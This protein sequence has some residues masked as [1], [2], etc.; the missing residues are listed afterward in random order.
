M[1]RT[2]VMNRTAAYFVLALLLGVLG[3]ATVAASRSTSPNSLNTASAPTK[4]ASSP[5]PNSPSPAA[6]RTP[7]DFGA[8]PH[9]DDSLGWLNTSGPS[10]P[11]NLTS[12][13]TLY[14]FWTFECYNCKNTLPTLRGLYQR[15]HQYGLEIV[16]IHTPEFAAER[17]H[18]NVTK[19]T[20][21][22]NVTWPVVF[23][24]HEINWHGWGNHY[25]PHI[26]VADRSARVRFDH[27][28]EGA[29][30]ELE[31]TIRA[32]LH[33]DPTSPRSTSIA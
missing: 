20:K 15:Y 11:P 13:V 16:G 6:L 4:A 24:D 3:V 28:G 14:E 10:V 29:Y 27:V 5:A 19:A 31:D 12:A 32:L 1:L 26:Y 9:L 23:D 8:V 21:D 30:D 22:L 2:T 17:D 18:N 7:G 25:W 33:I